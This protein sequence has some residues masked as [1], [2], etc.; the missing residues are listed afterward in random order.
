M[1]LGTMVWDDSM[2]GARQETACLPIEGAAFSAQL[3]EAVTHI[4][5]SYQ[6]VVQPELGEGETIR[7]SIPADPDVRN[8]SYNVVGGQV[9]YRENSVMVQPDLN[10]T[11]QERIKGMVAL[12][13]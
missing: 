12:R 3:A 13:D 1:V 7:E 6:A 10:A 8:Y 9:Y 4:T 11:V 5:G 2:Y